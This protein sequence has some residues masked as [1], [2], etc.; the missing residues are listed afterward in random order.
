MFTYRPMQFNKQY[1]IRLNVC[2][3]IN[4]MVVTTYLFNNQWNNMYCIVCLI[5]RNALC[6]RMNPN[7]YTNI[8]YIIHK[9]IFWVATK[10]YFFIKILDFKRMLSYSM[11]YTSYKCSY[12][13]GK[14]QT[15]IQQLLNILMI[16]VV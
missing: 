3:T 9:C 1:L 13:I 11:I 16:K 10:F 2:S 7:K 12:K 4:L 14:P 15:R 5:Q 6:S 8:N